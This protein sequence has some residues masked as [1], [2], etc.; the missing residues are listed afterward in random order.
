MAFDTI[1]SLVH[2]IQLKQVQ[3]LDNKLE[4]EK[5]A[6]QKLRGSKEKDIS[7]LLKAMSTPHDELDDQVES[8]AKDDR[9]EQ[10]EQPAT[11]QGSIPPPPISG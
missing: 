7:E 10:Q 9:P 4:E 1:R 3:A 5:S 8:E 11:P 6:R 2:R